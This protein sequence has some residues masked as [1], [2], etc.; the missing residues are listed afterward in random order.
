MKKHII[1]SGFGSALLLMLPWALLAATLPAE[2]PAVKTESVNTVPAPAV[3]VGSTLE[4]LT[5]T[6]IAESNAQAKYLI[7][8]KKADEEGYRKVAKLFR[9]TSLAQEIHAKGHAEVIK[10]LGGSAK[11]TPEK[12]VVGTT[13]ENLEAALKDENNKID[14]LFPAYL[15]KATAENNLK[16]QH[17]FGGLK[18][19]ESVHTKLYAVALANLEKWKTAGDFFVC[20]VCGNVVEKIDFEYCSICKA[21]ISEFVKVQ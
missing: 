18:V 1:I 9:A 17:V 16:A 12:F 2:K 11:V 19:V 15:Q 3:S 4:N 13:K 20:K 7:Y 6:F 14:N 8:A 10:S 21:P 5:K